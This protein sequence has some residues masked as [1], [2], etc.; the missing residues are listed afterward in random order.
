MAFTTLE[1]VDVEE[2]EDELS[3]MEAEVEAEEGIKVELPTDVEE[4]ESLEEGDA[5]VED[6]VL[7]V[8]ESLIE[9]E[10]EDPFVAEEVGEEIVEV[11]I[12][13]EDDSLKV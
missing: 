1:E 3:L 11:G 10:V 9:R 13:E 6:M 8:A 2:V 4:V 12:P 5:D 7:E